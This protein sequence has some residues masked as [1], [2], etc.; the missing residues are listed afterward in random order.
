M[1]FAGNY[2]AVMALSPQLDGFW[3]GGLSFQSEATD[4]IS[5]AIDLPSYVGVKTEQEAVSSLV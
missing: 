3:V 2:G 5:G 4:F 1:E